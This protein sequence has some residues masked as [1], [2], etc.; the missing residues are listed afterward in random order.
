MLYRTVYFICLNL[1][2]TYNVLYFICWIKFDLIRM[3]VVFSLKSVK[4]YTLS[5]VFS[6]KSEKAYT[7][8]VN[9][10][11]FE[12][13]FNRYICII[14]I[15][16]ISSTIKFCYQPKSTFSFMLL[17]YLCGN[18]KQLKNCILQEYI[19]YTCT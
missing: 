2:L 5:V 4:A 14:F 17:K 12:S 19:F 7:L 1:L 11:Y 15:I 8:S 18:E 10:D 3:H 6:L 9:N 16:I 13:V